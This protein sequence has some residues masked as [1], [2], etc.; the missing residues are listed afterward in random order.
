MTTE[1]R[2][3]EAVAASLETSGLDF[4]A[5]RLIPSAMLSA[6]LGCDELDRIFMIMELED[7]FEIE[8]DD[9]AFDACVTLQDVVELIGRVESSK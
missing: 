3:I 1:T 7:E 9:E 5:S 4:T 8:I 6:D 2:V